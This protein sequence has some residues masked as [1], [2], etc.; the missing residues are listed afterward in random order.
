MPPSSVRPPIG[1]PSNYIQHKTIQICVKAEIELRNQNTYH[2]RKIERIG[3]P[4]VDTTMYKRQ[5]CKHSQK[6]THK[7][8]GAT[9]YISLRHTSHPET[10]RVVINDPCR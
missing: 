5:Y 10:P 1:F 8:R 6:E 9:K 3:L 7:H 2:G 4:L